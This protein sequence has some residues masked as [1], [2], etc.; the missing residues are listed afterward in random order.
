MSEIGD[1]GAGLWLIS[2]SRHRETFARIK[3]R[4]GGAFYL[5]I[6]PFAVATVNLTAQ[7]REAPMTTTLAQVIV[8]TVGFAAGYTCVLS[9]PIGNGIDGR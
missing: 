4:F 6:G 8:L 3:P 2:G 5:T 7:T 1:P 9:S